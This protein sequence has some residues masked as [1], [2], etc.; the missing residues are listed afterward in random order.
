MNKRQRKKHHK[1]ILEDVAMDIS[2]NSSW[3]KQIFEAEYEEPI[4]IS[5]VHPDALPKYVREEMVQYKLKFY[6]AKTHDCPEYFDEGMVIFKFYPVE[7]PE[8]VQ[9]SGNNPRVIQIGIFATKKH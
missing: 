1:H 8:L 4:L 3:R 6:V 5:Y 2:V 9:F 7:F